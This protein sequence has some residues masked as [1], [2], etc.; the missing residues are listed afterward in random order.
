MITLESNYNLEAV[1]ASSPTLSR[2]LMLCPSHPQ[3]PL[4]LIQVQYQVRIAEKPGRRG[5]E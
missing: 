4:L 5:D 2:N 1:E 3:T